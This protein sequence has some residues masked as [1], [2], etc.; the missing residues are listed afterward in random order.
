[1]VLS[2]IVQVC[3]VQQSPRG[4]I[5]HPWPPQKPLQQFTAARGRSTG[6]CPH[7]LFMVATVVVLKLYN[8][9]V[10]NLTNLSNYELPLRHPSAR[11]CEKFWKLET[12]V[13]D[14]IRGVGG[15]LHSL[16]RKFLYFDYNFNEFCCLGSDSLKVS[17]DSDS[18]V[19]LNW[20]QPLS[21]PMMAQLIDAMWRY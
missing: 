5:Q 6:V 15:D 1:M 14:S 2:I 9:R 10:S 17:I 19:A 11:Y 16:E 3:L 12:M 7:S 18:V 13:S 8:T 4:R 20:R 21:E